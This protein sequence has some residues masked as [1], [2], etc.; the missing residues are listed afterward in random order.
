[1]RLCD[2]ERECY[3]ECPECPLTRIDERMTPDI[4]RFLKGLPLTD[5][6]TEL[7]MD[8]FLQ[9]RMRG[10]FER[11]MQEDAGIRKIMR[12]AGQN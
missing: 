11:L 5:S 4:R 2:L 3:D 6:R 10:L 1:M 9:G 7:V 12:R 8:A